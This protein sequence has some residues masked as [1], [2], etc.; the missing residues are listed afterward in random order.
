MNNS[1][2]L[3]PG[4]SFIAGKRGSGKTQALTWLAE[5]FA[6]KGLPVYVFFPWDL[7]EEHSTLTRLKQ[8]HPEIHELDSVAEMLNRLRNAKK[9]SVFLLDDIHNDVIQKNAHLI[10]SSRRVFD[11]L[12]ELDNLAKEFGHVIV[13]TKT[14]Q[15]KGMENPL[16]MGVSTISAVP[17][18][19][20]G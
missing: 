2:G 7:F 10:G 14:V 16:E 1:M 3:K 18:Y 20:L 17:T 6:L 12:M 19:I 4:V 13:F 11:T 8:C 9:G 15:F 5:E